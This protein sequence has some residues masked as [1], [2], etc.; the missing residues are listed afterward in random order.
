MSARQETQTNGKARNNSALALG[1][2]L[3]VLAL[4]I[5]WVWVPLDTDSGLIEKVRRRW[6]IGDALAPSV[7]AVVLGLGGAFLAL[8][9]LMGRA[10]PLDLSVSNVVFALAYLV[11]LVA[12]FHV[13]RWVGP[14][15]VALSDQAQSYR[16]LRD[17]VPWKYLGFVSGGFLLVLASIVAVERRLSAR[18]VLV[19]LLAPL[20]IALIYDLPFDDLLLPPN[21]DL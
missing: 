9:A 19:A 11:L 1:L 18:A 16:S 4:L 8:V 3:F 17:T 13:M 12:A 10:E 2:A 14:G 20:A 15:L 7:A 21:G 5:L 6:V